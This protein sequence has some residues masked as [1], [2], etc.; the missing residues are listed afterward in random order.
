MFEKVSSCYDI[1]NFCSVCQCSCKGDAS[2]FK[3]RNMPIV[4]F[5]VGQAVG[6]KEADDGSTDSNDKKL[7][8]IPKVNV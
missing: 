3:N 2:G 7:W 5:D 1:L 8:F 6:C 4:K